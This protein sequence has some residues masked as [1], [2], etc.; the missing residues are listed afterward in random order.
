MQHIERIDP[1]LNVADIQRSLRFYVDVLHFSAAA[2]ATDQFAHV[3]RDGNGIYLCRGEQGGPRTWIWMS[4]EDAREMH[5]HL[6]E[7]HVKLLQ[8]PTDKPWGIEIRA[9]DPD[10]HV[11]RIGS[12]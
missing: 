9:E 12:E 11:L 6:H 10:G 5:R 2:W 1:I 7:H 8:E 4:V 3:S